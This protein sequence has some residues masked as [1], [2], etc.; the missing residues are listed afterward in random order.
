[1]RRLLPAAL[2]GLVVGGV[3]AQAPD[4]GEIHGL[5]LGLNARTM[6]LVGLPEEQEQQGIRLCSGA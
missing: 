2:I 1:M 6:S 5:K 4:Q 3:S